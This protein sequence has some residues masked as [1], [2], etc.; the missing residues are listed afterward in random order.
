MPAKI[1]DEWVTIRENRMVNG[2]YF[3]LVFD[4][5]ELSRD[6]QPGQFLNMQVQ[7][8]E[9]FVLRRPFSYY[10]I[11]GQRVEVL[12]EVLGRMTAV[13]SEKRKGDRLKILGPLGKPFTQKTKQKI[14]ILVAGGVGVPPLVFLAE[15]LSVDYLLIG[16]KS[17]D[18]VLPKAELSHVQG[19]VLHAT[20]DGSYGKQGF[21][22]RLLEEIIQN[23]NPE[24]IFI[25]TCGPTVMMQAVMNMA[26]DH[27]I[28]GEASLDK[29]MACGVGVC[30][31]CVVRTPEGW[32]PSCTQ[33]P[34]FPFERICEA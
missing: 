33:G 2:K 15:K 27:G 26:R 28:H 9:R 5:P 6:V 32:V 30:L 24:N 10:R 13:L 3:K 22:T 25:Q 34:V 17:R 21:V 4:S 1:F 7:P 19:K 23:E 14:R 29:E 18:E 20:N 31:G 11:Q 8:E 12:Y 16:T